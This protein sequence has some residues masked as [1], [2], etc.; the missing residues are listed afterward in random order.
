MTLVY[1]KN[2]TKHSK[3][4]WYMEKNQCREIFHMQKKNMKPNKA[5]MISQ[6]KA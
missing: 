1:T 6:K 5:R 3:I 2:V 4:H